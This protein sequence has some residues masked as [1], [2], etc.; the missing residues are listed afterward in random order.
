MHVTHPHQSR[1][2]F[3]PRQHRN[4]ESAD[5]TLPAFW[6]RRWV[7]KKTLPQ[8]TVPEGQENDTNVWGSH[9]SRP[10]RLD[11]LRLDWRAHSRVVH[12]VRVRISVNAQQCLDSFLGKKTKMPISNCY[13][14]NHRFTRFC[15]ANHLGK[16]IKE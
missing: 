10:V 3:F 11:R 14:L 4:D 1:C 15:F 5:F 13:I 9:A 6:A 7:P 16:N 12:R 2:W 8:K